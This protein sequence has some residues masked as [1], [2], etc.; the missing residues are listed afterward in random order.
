VA[1]DKQ[2]KE[3]IKIIKQNGRTGYRGDGIIITSPVDEV[4]KIRTDETGVLAL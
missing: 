1:L 3:I 4:F 2:V